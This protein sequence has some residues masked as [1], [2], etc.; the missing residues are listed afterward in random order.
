MRESLDV[1]LVVLRADADMIACPVRNSCR[2]I[3]FQVPCPLR[4]VVGVKLVRGANADFERLRADRI[5]KNRRHQQD[6]W[7]ACVPPPSDIAIAVL[8]SVSLSFSA[9]AF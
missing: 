7:A 3:E 4:R 2:E 9:A 5:R 8:E 6:S 1:A